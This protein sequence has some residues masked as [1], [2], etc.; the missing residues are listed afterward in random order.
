LVVGIRESVLEET[1]LTPLRPGL[2]DA[3]DPGGLST[4]TLGALILSR[5][6]ALE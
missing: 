5:N 1:T 3:L 2:L 6:S 4:P